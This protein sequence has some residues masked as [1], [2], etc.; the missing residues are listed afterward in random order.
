MAK[1][2]VIDGVYTIKKKLGKGGMATV[3]LAAVDQDAFDYSTLFAYTQVQAD[4]HTERRK[5]AEEV[6]TQL[7]GKKLDPATMR[8]ILQAKN[9][10][11]PEREVAVKLAAAGIDNSRFE[12]EWK[13]LLCLNHENL[14]QVYGG[15]QYEQQPY[16]AME[17]LQDMVEPQRIKQA[18]S[19]REKLQVLIHAGRGLQCLHDNGI[20][21]RDIKP[22]NIVTC[23]RSGG[24][25]LTKIT[26]LGLAKNIEESL[27]ITQTNVILGSPAY[28]APEQMDAP[29]DVDHRAD[30]YSLGAT[31]YE[32]VTGKH[33]YHEKAGPYEIIIAVSTKEPPT[34]V[35]E[36]VPD[37]P[38]PIANIIQ[39]A[40]EFDP[41]D[42]Y[43]SIEDLVAD[44]ETYLTLEAPAYLEALSFAQADK[45]KARSEAA[46]SDS[47]FKE[48]LR[49]KAPEQA[50]V[51]EERPLPTELDAYR[52]LVMNRKHAQHALFQ[53]CAQV[54]GIKY[55][56]AL[57]PRDAEEAIA[58]GQ[59]DIAVFEYSRQDPQVL[60]LYEKTRTRRIPFLLHGDKLERTDILL[61]ARLGAAAV[62]I[63]PIQEKPFQGKLLNLLEAA[64]KPA[65]QP[66]ESVTTV[67]LR[68]K[69]SPPERARAVLRSAPKIL[70]LPN[71]VTKVI[72]LAN[73][74]NTTAEELA[75]PVRSDSAIAAMVLRR[76]NSV[77]FG[78][79]RKIHTIRDAIV[80][81]GRRE[82]KQL[83]IT[84]SVYRLFDRK[85]KSFGFN[86]YLYWIH[87]LGAAI[88]AKIIAKN[89]GKGDA[90][91]T[92]LCGLLH[93]IGK[94]VFDDHLNEDYKQVIQRAGTEGQ[95]VCKVE[96]ELFMID[97]AFMGARITEKW[98]LPAEIT[99]AIE[100]H[101]KVAAARTGDPNAPVEL[102]PARIANMGNS[103]I[104]AMGAGHSGDFFVDD[105]PAPEWLRG[106]MRLEAI[107][108]YCDTIRR[109]L[110]EFADMLGIST[111]ESGLNS[112][113]TKK[114]RSVAIVQDGLGVLLRFFFAAR[115]F[116]TRFVSW[117][118]LGGVKEDIAFD[119]REMPASAQK[120]L[121]TP[122]A[123]WGQ[124]LFLL[125]DQSLRTPIHSARIIAPAN[126]FFRVEQ[127]V[128]EVYGET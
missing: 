105:I 74:P 17:Y 76:A 43:S 56:T 110:C 95:R 108:N 12:G 21:H 122:E 77:A 49:R 120:L 78:G 100:E 87:A 10:P 117:T 40:M 88:G 50:V 114:G 47:A 79:A 1:S 69:N 101:H 32:Y 121:Q 115:G 116:D 128:Q 34:A 123:F 93:D 103:I 72:T 36:L 51:T 65:A 31:L 7:V 2:S 37:V 30:V 44:L 14:V 18:F 73:N 29:R 125:A 83:A 97:H 41:K 126:D 111:K 118:E 98:N 46:S 92:F 24:G 91:D 25:Y 67:M 99:T 9:I 54:L 4:T 15:G 61:S 11:I 90:E 81:I 109:E 80:R 70:V 20:I 84:M 39:T 26:D 102:S 68:G 35:S 13:N 85:E 63:N 94:I 75:Q 19:L 127:V 16:Y 104:K 66:K 60:K 96:Q 119:A 23:E 112:R 71:A 53:R 64:G 33:P 45:A 113:A 3:Y 48:L 27:G 6:A 8:T 38:P 62:M 82:T 58:N 22:G 107:P 89:H 106:L 5:K 28:M 55:L 59:V 52:L 86:R 57:H 42:R 124:N